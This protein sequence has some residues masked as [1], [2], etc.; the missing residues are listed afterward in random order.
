[1]W[2]SASIAATLVLAAIA[3]EDEQIYT[4]PVSVFMKREFAAE[5]LAE[6][7]LAQKLTA[8]MLTLDAEASMP[9]ADHISVNLSPLGKF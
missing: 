7:S 6:G 5:I 4:Q 1:M 3:S 8:K 9:G 2:L